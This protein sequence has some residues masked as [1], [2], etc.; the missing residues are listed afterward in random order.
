MA[1]PPHEPQRVISDLLNVFEL[2]VPSLDETD[3][4][5]VALAVSARAIAPQKLVRIHAAVPVIPIDFQDTGPP[6]RPK[7]DRRRHEGRPSQPA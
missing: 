2:E 6:R 7:L 4:A 3:W 5:L 1:V